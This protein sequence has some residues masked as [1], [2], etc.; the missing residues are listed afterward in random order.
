MPLPSILGGFETRQKH[1]FHIFGARKKI[2]KFFFQEKS[3]FFGKK[4]GFI[5]NNRDLSEK[6]AIFRRNFF[7]RFFPWIFFPLPPTT[8]K[9]AE[10]SDYF[11]LALNVS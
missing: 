6:S 11:F 10:I 9:S 8:E 1:F 5:G 2:R 3:V 4:S 7:K